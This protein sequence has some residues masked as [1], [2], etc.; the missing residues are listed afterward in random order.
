LPFAKCI[1]LF[2]LALLLLLLP[3]CSDSPPTR[4]LKKYSLSGTLSATT[5]SAVDSDT[6]D[7]A[8]TAVSNNQFSEAQALTFPATVGGYLVGLPTGISGDHFASQAD[9]QDWYHIVLAAGQTIQLTIADHDGDE[10]NLANPNFDLFLYASDG[11][12]LLQ[13]SEGHGRQELISVLTTGEY[14]V[15]VL[16]KTASATGSNYTLSISDTPAAQGAR[17]TLHFEDEFV[18]GEVIVKFRDSATAATPSARAAKAADLGLMLVA[19]QAGAPMLFRLNTQNLTASSVARGAAN[20]AEL[21]AQLKRATLEQVKALRRRSDVATA[22]LNY[23]RRAALVPNDTRYAEQW[24]LDNINLAQA[25]DT[26]SGDPNLVVAVL[27]TGVLFDHPDLAGRFCLAA[28][29]CAGYDFVVALGT[30]ADGD[31]LD[32][33]PTDPGID[34]TSSVSSSFHGTHVS[35][36]LGAV[37]NNSEGIAGVDWSARI[38]PVRV[39]GAGGGASYD[40]MQGVRY[41]AGLSNDSGLIPAKPARVMNLS[42]G[43][44]GFSQTEQDLFDQLYAAGVLVVAASGNGG[45]N[46]PSYPAAYAHVLSVG[47]VDLGGNL[48][49]Y[50][51]TGATLD[52]VAPGGDLDADL[53]TDGVPDA[54]LST[55]GDDTLNPLGYTYARKN[56]TSM[57]APH[58][59]G[60]A[61]LMLAVDPALT[62]S[63]FDILLAN[64]RLTQDLGV[65]GVTV[66]H[67]SFGYGLI[68]AQLAVQAAADLAAGG[69][70]PPWLSIS[71]NLLDFGRNT[72]QLSFSLENLGG[73]L[74]NVVSLT[75]DQSWLSVPTLT[76]ETQAGSG[77]GDYSLSVDRSGLA[78]GVYSGNLT[79]VTDQPQS[80][81]L[82][83]LLQVGDASVANAGVQRIE[84]LDATS[85]ASLQTLRVAAD[86]L[87]GGYPYSFSDLDPGSYRVTATSDLNNDGQSCDA[88]E[89]C[90]SYPQLS[91]PA[92][93]NLF[94]RNLSGLD[95]SSGFDSNP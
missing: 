66:W 63:D 88:G 79:I 56:G 26:T 46:L 5:L 77:L 1:L 82:A 67:D 27:D 7:P 50:S 42:L 49:Y 47:A 10:T 89:A 39:L 37:G 84:L 69:E 74:L 58:V 57:A 14:F 85:G 95:F 65:D 2:L 61:A 28:D 34:G 33:D 15:Q 51:N 11:S 32:A 12:N 60:V 78:A 6:N 16:D 90:G 44:Y 38:M 91:A 73:G 8:A 55:V 20:Q 70:L 22:D 24:S 31:G 94:D 68:D 21:V 64:G 72:N 48:A 4:G 23:I 86:P 35:G 29:E 83:V 93:I 81:R 9:D 17:A 76:N 36:I 92:I 75:P 54:I 13:S 87:S 30:A 25:W 41:A 59:S 40:I 71:S 80:Y 43:G 18:P 52:L 45:S 62:P 53:N 19:G 3:A